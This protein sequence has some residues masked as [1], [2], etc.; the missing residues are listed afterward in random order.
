MENYRSKTSSDR[1]AIAQDLTGYKTANKE[2]Q[3]YFHGPQS[4][5]AMLESWYKGIKST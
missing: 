3:L 1:I 2:G 5:L 4:I